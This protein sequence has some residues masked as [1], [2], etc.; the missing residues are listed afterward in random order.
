MLR[1]TATEVIPL[2]N[3]LLKLMF[4]DGETRLFDVKPYIQGSW[5]KELLDPAYFR[6]V[7]TNGY[8]VE[9]VNGQDLCPDELYY[10]SQPC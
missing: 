9:W 10:C 6:S 8:S 4:D 5:Y 3:Y 1:P 7:K 2:D